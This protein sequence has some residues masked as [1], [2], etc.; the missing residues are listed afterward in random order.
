MARPF[1]YLVALVIVGVLSGGV[2][3]RA[4]RAL[5]DLHKW[6][7]YFALFAPDSSVPW[8]SASVRLDTY[9]SAPVEFAAYA[10]DPLDVI[11][12][13]ANARPRVV[14]TKHL[15]PVARWQF[16]PP[17]GYHFES[18]QVNVPLG[19][20]EGFFIIEARRNNV[21]EQVWINRTRVGLLSKES[22]GELVLYGADLGTGHALANMRVS[23]VVNNRFD[24]RA[25]DSHGTVAWRDRT[26]PVFAMAQWGQSRAFLS[27]LPSAP[28]P[29]SVAGVMVDAPS[30][31]AGERI[32]VVG[33]ARTRAGTS[34]RAATGE[35]RIAMRLRGAEIAQAHARFDESGSFAAELPVPRNVQSG[36]YALIATAGAATAGTTM[37]VDADAGGLSLHVDAECSALCNPDADVPVIVRA[38]RDGA[39]AANVSIHLRAVRSPH[40]EIGAPRASSWGTT[41]VLDQTLQTGADGTARTVLAHPSDGLASTY[42]LE[43]ESGAATAAGR[44]AVPTSTLALRIDAPATPLSAGSPVAFSILGENS[45]DGRAAAGT[46]VRVQLVHG[47]SIAEQTIMLDEHGS[48]HG[49][50]SSAP[51]G[52]NLLIARANS[53]ASQSIDAQEVQIVPQAAADPLQTRSQDVHIALDKP[54]YRSGERIAVNAQ[55]PGSAGDA[56]LTYETSQGCDVAVA[57]VHAG[58][59]VGTF[60]AHNAVGSIQIGAAFVHDGALAWSSADVDL[61]APG[62]PRAAILRT[63]ARAYAPGS[64][65][66]VSLSDQ[67]A[68]TVV[69]RLLAGTPGGAARFDD[70]PDLLAAGQT[71]SQDTAAPQ[72]G[73]HAWVDATATRAL[74]FGFDRRAGAPPAQLSIAPAD[75]RSLFWEVTREH[76][77]SFQIPMP[78]AR[79]QYT[80]SVLE[81]S[82]DGRVGAASSSVV[83]K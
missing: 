11:V 36:E 73:W 40:L 82:D 54:A 60:A 20:R 65:A 77:A 28:M 19:S 78:Q 69:V 4:A 34:L 18:S 24:V 30:V 80:I 23:F 56:L 26:R 15:T 42:G 59:A 66:T 49:S 81:F 6:D 75:S 79:G 21:A 3:A 1:R 43:V 50:F 5:L 12:A 13:G 64:T 9:S 14:A 22:P 10:V 46:P 8:K 17:A 74:S 68:R 7:G 38:T 29:S 57:P 45:S 27:L 39:P 44:V 41:M 51:L 67:G 25:T 62:R 48:A 71:A 37:H 35:V 61:D 32:R 76:P 52:T 33:F 58:K 55:S 2:P 53:G 47:A 70:A 31:R 83:V 63:D 16:T 72:G